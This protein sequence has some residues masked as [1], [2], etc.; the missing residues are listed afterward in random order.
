MIIC[1]AG[2]KY[3]HGAEDERVLGRQCH[4]VRPI[5]ERESE[6][7][8]DELS[9]EFLFLPIYGGQKSSQRKEPC[10][11]VVFVTSSNTITC[12]GRQLYV[13]SKC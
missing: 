7:E 6:T 11:S 10:R 3:R 9:D 12:V 4:L 5:L 8:S 13:E 2:P 1:G